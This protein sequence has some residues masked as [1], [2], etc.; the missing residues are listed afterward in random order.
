MD[1]SA[2]G[3]K[4][5][6]LH[7]LWASCASYIVRYITCDG[8]KNMLYIVHFKLLNHLR[9]NKIVNV[10]KFLFHLLKIMASK[11]QRR[12]SDTS[13]SHHCL[14][15]LLIKRSL[16]IQYPQVRWEDFRVDECNDINSLLVMPENVGIQDEP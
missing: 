5:M 3:M 7:W 13:L 2:Q 16:R 4:R 9:N 14:V 8:R 6:S 1:S 15:T 12:Q 10:P 11:Y